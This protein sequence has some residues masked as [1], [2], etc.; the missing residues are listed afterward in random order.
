MNNT[1]FT[2]FSLS[3]N[4]GIML[5]SIKVMSMVASLLSL[6]L[7]TNIHL[8]TLPLAIASGIVGA[9][10]AGPLLFALGWSKLNL[11]VLPFSVILLGISIIAWYRH[12]QFR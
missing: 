7:M 11:T 1:R 9:L 4:Q 8:A 10:L 12:E 3:T 5:I 6:H 2:I